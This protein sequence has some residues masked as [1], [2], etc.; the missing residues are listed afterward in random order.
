LLNLFFRSI[1]PTDAGGQFCDRG[2]VYRTAVFVA[3]TA[4]KTAAEQALAAAQSELGQQIVTPI[5]GAATF[6]NAEDYHQ[7]Y[8]KGSNIVLTRG[9]PKSQANAYKFYREGCG[10][11]E[12]IE[13]LWGSDAPFITH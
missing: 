5:L 2:D 6:Y 12:R 10:R 7:D 13:A 3:N 1:D 4:Q 11:D 8:Y 9:G